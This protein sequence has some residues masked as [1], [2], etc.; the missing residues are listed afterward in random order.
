[1]MGVPHGAAPDAEAT[2]KA[3]SAKA[4]PALTIR[5]IERRQTSHLFIALHTFYDRMTDLL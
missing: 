4:A 3:H 2:K 1:M 5:L